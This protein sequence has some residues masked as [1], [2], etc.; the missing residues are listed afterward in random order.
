MVKTKKENITD[1]E[2]VHEFFSF[3]IKR[4]TKHEKNATNEK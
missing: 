4:N 2:S 1:G 3:V